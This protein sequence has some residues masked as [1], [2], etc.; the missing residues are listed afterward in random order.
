MKISVFEYKDYKRFIND[1]I[2]QAPS[3]G[4]GLR[5]QLAEAIGCQTAYITHVL[6]GDYHFSFEQA[7]ACG[8]WL[9]LN[10]NEIEFLLLL[11]SLKRAG[12]KSLEKH[13]EKQISS[14]REH[15]SIL[16]KRIEIKESLS[17]EDQQIYYSSWLYAS[18]HMAL[19]IP[20]LQTVEA[21]QRYFQLSSARIISVLDF[22]KTHGLIKQEKNY[23]KVVQ[24][25]LHLELD[26]PL[27]I[28]HHTHWRLRAVDSLGSPSSDNLHYSG[29]MSL[30][31]EDYEWVREKLSHLLQ[32][33]V[34]RLRES[35][36]EKLA[37][38]C[39]DWFEV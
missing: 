7:E 38:L 1:W 5:T 29:V 27:L 17:K 39:F 36:D 34:E 31:R 16:K 28:Q 21:L 2:E 10:D 33:I 12:T 24:P 32:Q 9:E 26:S 11:V 22:L 6:S 30:S 13:I 35:K 19:L 4:R 15:Q 23:F 25:V 18:V 20:S 14:R 3:K 8:R 37:S